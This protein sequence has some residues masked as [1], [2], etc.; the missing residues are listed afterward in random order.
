MSSSRS[1][2]GELVARVKAVLRRKV[3]TGAEPERLVRGELVIDLEAHTASWSGNEVA[4]TATEF[5]L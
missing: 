5:S 4:L 2:P 1:A 3:G